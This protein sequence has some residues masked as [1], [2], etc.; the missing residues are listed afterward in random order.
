MAPPRSFD[1]ELLKQLVREHPDWTMHQYA[2]ELTA[3]NPAGQ[4][5]VRRDAVTAAIGRNRDRW[6]LDGVDAG[7]DRRQPVYGEL[8]PWSPMKEQFKMH[9]YLRKLRTIA[10]MR[11]GLTVDS[12]RETR[13]ALQF[14]KM[15]RE[16]KQVVTLGPR[17]RPV[18]VQAREDELDP[19][20]QLIELVRRAEGSPLASATR[21]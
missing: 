1:Y 19:D 12:P 10:R 4:E 13:Q 5:P 11:R 2:T 8:I 9:V 3:H 16:T 18:L 20:G 15:L 21:R 6:K 7:W 17:G 14:E